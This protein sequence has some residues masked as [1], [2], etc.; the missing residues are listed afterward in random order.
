MERF[1]PPEDPHIE[2]MANKVK[3][4][5]NITDG[6]RTREWAI[7]AVRL[8]TRITKK[9]KCFEQFYEAVIKE[10]A[11]TRCCPGHNEKLPGTYGRTNMFLLK[12]FR[13][14]CLRYETQIKSTTYCRY[15]FEPNNRKICMN[16]WH[17]RW[18]ELPCA[19]VAP[20][21]VNKSLD[22]GEPPLR[23]DN[24][25]EEDMMWDQPD[26]TEEEVM[27]SMKIPNV[28]MKGDEIKSL[29]ERHAA[30]ESFMEYSSP[31]STSNFNG[32]VS[33]PSLIPSPTS[34]PSSFE[35]QSPQAADEEEFYYRSGLSSPCSDIASPRVFVRN[36]RNANRVDQEMM[37]EVDEEV[38]RAN[39]N[40]N[41][42]RP[43][44]TYPDGR[45]IT[46]IEPRPLFRSSAA[47]LGDLARNAG[48]YECVEYEENPCWLGLMYYEEGLSIGDM[49]TFQGQ[50]C[51]IDGF[52][53]TEA[54]STSR[55]SVGFYNNPN[56]SQSTSEVRGLIGRGVRLYLLAGE[57]YIE[58]LCSVPVFVQS[59][60]ANMKNN[61]QLN[62]VSKLQPSGTMKVF[63]MYQFSKQLAAA[64]EKTY[65]DVYSLSRMCTVRLS[66]CKGWGEHYRRSTVLRSPVWFQIHLNNPMTWIDSVL[67]CMGAPPKVCSSRT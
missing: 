32:G 57:V 41:T 56:R 42:Q 12:V 49:G 55:F 51:L 22:Y 24:P 45:P 52:T 54:K 7:K 29:Y 63:D 8:L 36:G 16:P 25:Y 23:S 21:V 67:T 43:K 26:M 17:Y 60:S 30:E 31:P 62:T 2:A 9:Y 10:S 4:E 1:P 37:D 28:T 6:D 44:P 27:A 48:T 40:G 14:P 50:H 5:T 34:F 61:F 20:I 19:P 47:E 3:D 65:Q 33:L 18:V 59:I 39:Q 13:F 35:P 11:T 15:I 38:A 53:S 66:F 46:P 58:N 64:A